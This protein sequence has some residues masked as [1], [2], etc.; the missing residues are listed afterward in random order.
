MKRQV[1]PHGARGYAR[2]GRAGETGASP[3]GSSH[4]SVAP[5]EDVPRETA[6]DDEIWWVSQADEAVQSLAWKTAGSL[7]T[8]LYVWQTAVEARPSDRY[9]TIYNCIRTAI[10]TLEQVGRR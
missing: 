7:R 2:A 1:D 10:E 8:M 5:K 6:P 9:D 3:Q 4:P